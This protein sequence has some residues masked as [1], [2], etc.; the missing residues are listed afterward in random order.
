M[1]IVSIKE[2]LLEKYK[3][4]DPEMLDKRGRPCLLVMRLRYKGKK[5]MFAVP[6]RS[7]IAGSVPKSQY[8]SLPPRPTTRSG[9]RHGLHYIKMFPIEK[10]FLERYRIDE[11]HSL[12]CM[13]KIS[14]NEKRIVDDCQSYLEKYEKGERPPFSTAI[15]DL[16][17]TL[18][19]MREV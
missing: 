14:D 8:F 4:A 7:N 9:N 15:D 2:S 5:R 16:I 1:K 13:K 18:E 12:L 3:Q 10:C 11:P 17:A 6:F 19:H